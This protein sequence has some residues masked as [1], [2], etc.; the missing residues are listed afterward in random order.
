MRAAATQVGAANVGSAPA[1]ETAIGVQRTA[2]RRA[3]GMA[4]P[5]RAVQGTRIEIR[6]P[7]T[8][9]APRETVPKRSN[10]SRRVTIAASIWLASTEILSAQCTSEAYAMFIARSVVNPTYQRPVGER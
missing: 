5:T 10:R 7:A 2:K 1:S 4:A 8:G 6:R 3:G 9:E